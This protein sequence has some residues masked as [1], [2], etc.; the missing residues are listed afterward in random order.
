MKTLSDKCEM[1]LKRKKG[2]VCGQCLRCHCKICDMPLWECIGKQKLYR[3][4][5]QWD[6]W[7]WFDDQE[8][9]DWKVSR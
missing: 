3:N 1:C 4:L 7:V 8:I 6:R 5:S 9:K 2:V